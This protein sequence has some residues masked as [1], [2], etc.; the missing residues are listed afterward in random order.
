MLRDRSRN[1]DGHW[2]LSD[3][4]S[5]ALT[6]ISIPR[7]ILT[8]KMEIAYEMLLF[9]FVLFVLLWVIRAPLKFSFFFFKFL[10]LFFKFLRQSMRTEKEI[11]IKSV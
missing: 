3:L 2:S 5:L 4:G 9:V 7:R 11:Q 10:F 8:P 6:E 1:V